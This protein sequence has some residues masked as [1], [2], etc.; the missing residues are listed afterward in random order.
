MSNTPPD[1]A[2]PEP[3]A[4]SCAELLA[5]GDSGRGTRTIELGG[6]E[7]DVFCDQETDGGGWMLVARSVANG[8]VTFGWSTPA[9]SLSDDNSP[10]AIGRSDFP[11]SE[12]LIGNRD[13]AK[14]WGNR[15]YRV[16]LPQ[17]FVA[18]CAT[19]P[20]GTT[21][22]NVAGTCTNPTM[23]NFA[24]RTSKTDSFW[25]RDVD[26][27]NPYG[28]FPDGWRTFYDDCVGGELN[29]QQGMIFAR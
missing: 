27:D 22:S 15:V 9:G 7:V 13:D 5:R 4:T 3:T 29:G 12:L 19:T 25:F 2:E 18:D 23:F 8:T 28:L 16:A 17:N 14:G 1:M 24:G 6:G 11:L 26:G 20:C 10:Y 21:V